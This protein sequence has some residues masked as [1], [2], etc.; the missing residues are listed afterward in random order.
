MMVVHA[1]NVSTVNDLYSLVDQK[2]YDDHVGFGDKNEMVEGH[3]DV[4]EN[5]TEEESNRLIL[6]FQCWQEARRE[7]RQRVVVDLDDSANE[8]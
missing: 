7:L 6:P 3:V 5:D 4:L 8:I 2:E 1:L